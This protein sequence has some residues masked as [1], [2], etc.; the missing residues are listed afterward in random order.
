MS[1]RRVIVVGGGIAGLAAAF[2]LMRAG[3][4]VTVLERGARAG[5]R[6]AATA[7]VGGLTL[8]AGPDSFV[9]RKPWA[10]ELCREL[11]VPLDRPG[12]DGAF[13]WTDGGLVRYPKG[14]AFGIPG[15]IGDVLRWPG[16]SR[17]GRLRAAGDLVRRARKGPEE[18]TLGALLR[19][20]LGDEATDVAVAPLLGG[21]FAGDVDRL[22]ALA[23][24]PELIE[25]ER[26]Q[27]SLIRGSQA[28][29]RAAG[30]MDPGP[31]FLRP[32]GGTGRLTDALV[33]ALGDRV[34]VGVAVDRLAASGDGYEVQGESGRERSDAL[35]LASDAAS[36]GG[37]LAAAWPQVAGELA[38]IRYV[39]TADVLLVYPEGTASSLPEGPGFVA[40]RG[41]APMTAST[42]V[43]SKWPDPAFGARAIVR[44]FVG[45]DGDEDVLEAPDDDIV[46][47]CS[48]H[49]AALV[50][51][52]ERP[53]AAG[54]VR[55][56]RAMP[57]Y[58]IGH[59]DRVRRIREGLPRGVSVI[60]NA[61]DGVGIAD[62]V[63]AAN[64]A[65]ERIIGTRTDAD[66]ET[67]R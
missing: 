37:I 43:S 10:V 35:V 16:V 4:D 7:S 15:D 26:L 56:P 38:G 53:R 25:W 30:R 22:S 32:R 65:A 60:G 29:T 63:R 66:R 9:A 21:L 39:S 41:R 42:W 24:F 49:L 59:R 64:E 1:G 31:I 20:R 2:R 18:E 55:W 14:S 17:A 54:V 62:T 11:G 27:G 34:R 57:Q 36:A 52:P 46:E 5:G 6:L 67:V 40:P 58:E 19:R 23:T 51:L 50:D 44:C 12:A 48:R 33:A 3:L 47:A 13:L 28:A 61:Y 45:A 8:D